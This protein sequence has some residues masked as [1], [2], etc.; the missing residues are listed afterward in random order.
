MEVKIVISV[1]G[2]GPGAEG[3]EMYHILIWMGLYKN[4]ESHQDVGVRLVH[5]KA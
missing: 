4:V 2:C 3:L 1:E 5:F